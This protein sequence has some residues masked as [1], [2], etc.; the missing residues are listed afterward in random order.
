M[1]VLIT[2]PERDAADLKSRIEAL[3]ASVIL[4]PL[5]RIEHRALD[6]ADLDGASALIVTSRNAL[7]SLAASPILETARRLEIFAVGAATAAMARDLGFEKIVEGPGTGAGLAAEITKRPPTASGPLVHLAGDHLAFDM[8]ASLAPPGIA[9]KVIR[10]Y[11]TVAAETLP[12]E[13]AVALADDTLDAVILMS[14]LTAKTWAKLASDLKSAA[15][16][17][18]ISHVCLSAKVASALPPPLSAGALVAKT[19][20]IDEIVTLLYRLAGNTKNR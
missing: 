13:A 16:L 11:Q 12:A 17:A 5:L 6:H 10:A 2:R 18:R 3:G 20:Q 19:P 9:V 15:D 14:P 4:A 8:A 1:K 7:R